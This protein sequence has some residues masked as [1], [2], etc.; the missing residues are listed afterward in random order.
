MSKPLLDL[1]SVR[2]SRN[3]NEFE[4][5]FLPLPFP[6][7]L[8]DPITLIS[9]PMVEIMHDDNINV[10][11]AAILPISN[12]TVL[13]TSVKHVDKHHLDTHHKHVMDGSMMMGFV[14]IM[15][16]REN[17]METLPESVDEHMLFMYVCFSS[18]LKLKSND[19]LCHYSLFL[20]L[21][22]L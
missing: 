7:Y 21:L 2:K 18:Y 20:L 4:S 11:S 22:F 12:G 17:T 16:L 13:F 6:V 19:F 8:D 1:I 10:L 5:L 15:T 14:V 3:H 9:L